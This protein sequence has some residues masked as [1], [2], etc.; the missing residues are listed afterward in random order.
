[1]SSE[2]TTGEW[3]IV[4]RQ[5]EAIARIGNLGLRGVAFDRLLGE[6]L[7]AVSESLDVDA[8]ILFELAADAR[9]LTIRGLVIDGHLLERSLV[10]E[11][12]VPAG[13]DRSR[14]S[15]QQDGWSRRRT[16]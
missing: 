13:H 16:T 11:L 4:A 6:T 8:A 1:M 2:R 12:A 14:A 15:A 7:E 3:S 5:Q 10:D 9:S